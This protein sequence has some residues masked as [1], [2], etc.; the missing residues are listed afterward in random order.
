MLKVLLW[1]FDLSF[2]WTV[3]FMDPV[4]LTIP[5][6]V[7]CAAKRKHEKLRGL[8]ISDRITSGVRQRT[9]GPLRALLPGGFRHSVFVLVKFDDRDK[10]SVYSN[11]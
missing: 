10:K 3:Y 6:P 9:P 5:H 2:L 11:F 7:M 1:L 8:Q 4:K